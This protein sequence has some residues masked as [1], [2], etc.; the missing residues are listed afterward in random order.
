MIFQFIM[1]TQIFVQTSRDSTSVA[2]HAN[3][4]SRR[5][6]AACTRYAKR[7]IDARIEKVVEPDR[8]AKS[9]HSGTTTG[10]ARISF[11]CVYLNESCNW[12]RRWTCCAQAACLPTPMYHTYEVP[13]VDI[14]AR[15]F[16]PLIRRDPSYWR[17]EIIVRCDPRHLSRHTTIILYIGRSSTATV[18]LILLTFKLEYLT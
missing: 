14:S 2:R 15:N 5:A 16:A 17:L 11:S 18:I 13:H 1:L 7:D 4:L 10:A 8:G 3:G 6:I 9:R 12:A